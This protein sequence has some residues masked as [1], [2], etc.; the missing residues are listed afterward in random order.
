MFPLFKKSGS[1]N[2][3]HFYVNCNFEQFFLCWHFCLATFKSTVGIGSNNFTH[4]FFLNIPAVIKA[5]IKHLLSSVRFIVCKK[6]SWR[7]TNVEFLTGISVYTVY[8]LLCGRL[9]SK[10]H[11]VHLLLRK[12]RQ[13]IFPSSKLAVTHI[14]LQA[15]K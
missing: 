14:N 13:F 15:I 10:Q 3:W 8:L 6:F 1:G 4:M 9:W 11:W 5:N 2:F 12:R 7:R